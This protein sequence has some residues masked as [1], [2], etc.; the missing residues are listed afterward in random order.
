[1]LKP[2]GGGSVG[3]ALKSRG[4]I[5]ASVATFAMAVYLYFSHV[6]SANRSCGRFLKVKTV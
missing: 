6:P 2:R 4:S 1:M 5:A 3:K